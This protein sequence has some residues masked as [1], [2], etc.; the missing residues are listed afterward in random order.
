VRYVNKEIKKYMLC[1][2]AFLTDYRETDIGKLTYKIIQNICLHNE[3]ERDII[4]CFGRLYQNKKLKQL[5]KTYKPGG[6]GYT[7][8]KKEF[9]SIAKLQSENSNVNI[10]AC[11]DINACTDINTYIKSDIDVR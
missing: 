8:A 9:E 7:L 2:G 4:G 6:G 1:I 3:G 10:N 5:K 11:M